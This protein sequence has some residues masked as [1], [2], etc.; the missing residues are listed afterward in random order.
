MICVSKISYIRTEKTLFTWKE[1]HFCFLLDVTWPWI[2]CFKNPVPMICADCYYII[3][4]YNQE[5]HTTISAWNR[6]PSRTRHQNKVVMTLFKHFDVV[7][8]SMQHRS[9]V[10]CR[11]GYIRIRNKCK[12]LIFP[13]LVSWK[14]VY[15]RY[16]RYFSLPYSY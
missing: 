13:F 5:T 10:V 14:M 1:K 12:F 6:H 9:N 16:F 11:L 3:L 15:F 2:L 4:L 7:T 8:T